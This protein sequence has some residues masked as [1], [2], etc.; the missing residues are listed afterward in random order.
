MAYCKEPYTN[1][2]CLEIKEKLIAS[3]GK[4]YIAN[5]LYDMPQDINIK[6]YINQ[7]GYVHFIKGNNNILL[8]NNGNLKW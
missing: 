7:R 4:S 5:T 1:K 6:W 3:V 8:D 2:K